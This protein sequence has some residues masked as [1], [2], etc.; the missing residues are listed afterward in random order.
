[1]DRDGATMSTKRRKTNHSGEEGRRG[2]IP[3]KLHLWTIEDV[4]E[5]YSSIDAYEIART[6]RTQ[7]RKE[8]K[9]GQTESLQY[10]EIDLDEFGS[11]L[12]KH[13]APK[14]ETESSFLDIGMGSG[15]A[16]MVAAGSA[17]FSR[18]TGIEI[19]GKLHK[20]A[21]GILSKLEEASSTGPSSVTI[22]CDDCFNVAWDQDVIFLPITCFTSEMVDK[23]AERVQSLQKGTLLIITSTLKA[24]DDKTL[25]GSTIKKLHEER[26]KYGKG[27]MRFTV[28]EKV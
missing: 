7:L 3:D 19:V 9:H 25:C 26:Y 12:E 15:K 18:V 17:I 5:A 6:H 8:G 23:C 1:M 28:Y 27:A 16:V 2:E 20:E 10:G 22:I 24:L 11:L 14:C 13:V 4:K 21:E